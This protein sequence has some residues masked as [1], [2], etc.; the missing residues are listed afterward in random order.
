[1]IK[2]SLKGLAKYVASS[3]ATQ[4]RILQQFKY[5]AADEPFA[6]RLYYREATDC[7]KTYISERRSS[8][9]LQERARQL[10]TAQAGDSAVRAR[11]RSQNAKAVL[12][13]EQYFGNKELELLATPKLALT[14]YDVAISVVPDVCV[15]EGTAIKFIKVQF[16]GA[17]LP[18]QSTRVLTQCLLEAARLHGYDL[19][20]SS[21][22]YLDLPRGL[23]HTAPRANKRVL[24]DVRAACETIS[25]IW[26][27]IPP[28][29]KT[30]RSAAA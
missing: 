5:P 17:K 28:P 20:L 13:C 15:K 23:V 29:V 18:E 25:Q 2:L 21:A 19:S 3:P 9:W 22:I 11:R 16:G 14:F 24:L 10:F 7:L 30:K 8:H 4:R 6:M 12:L 1:M 26:E 27:S